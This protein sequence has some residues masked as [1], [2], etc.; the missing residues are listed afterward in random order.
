MKRTRVK[1]KALK[2]GQSIQLGKGL[3]T[4]DHDACPDYGTSAFGGYGVKCRR[5]QLNNPERI[6]TLIT[7]D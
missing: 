5:L 7:F 3:Y 1:V 2:K 6:V 4:V